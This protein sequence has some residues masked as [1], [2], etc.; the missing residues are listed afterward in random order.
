MPRQCLF[1]IVGIGASAGGLAAF[2]A[3]FTGMPKDSDPGMAFVIVQHLAPDHKSILCELIRRYTRMSVFEVEDGMVVQQNCAYIIPPGRDMAFLNGS[4]QL[5]PPAEPRGHRLPIDFFFRSLALDHHERAIGIIL[6]G[7]GSDG[8]LGLRAIKGEGGMIM[9]QSTDTAE[10]D[11]MPLSAIGTGLVDYVLPPTEMAERLISYTR[12][13]FSPPLKTATDENPKFGNALPK[14]FILL[15]SHTSHDFS[16]YKPSTIIRRIGRRMAVH[17]IDAIADYVHY[18]RQKPNEVQALFRDLLIGVTSFFR[19][20]EAFQILEDQVIPKLFNGKPAGSSIRIWIPGCST[21]EEAYS[22]AILL[23]E[24]VEALRQNYIVQVF[25]TD[26]DS[27]A[28]A[29]ARS[30]IYPASIAANIS[31]DRLARF[32]TTEKD[33][34]AYRID[35]S[36]RDFLFFS[37]HDLIKDPP[38]SKLDL[39][40]C[41][42]L[43]IY[44]G[45]ELQKN[46][47]PLF[48]YALKPNGTLFLGTS[49]GIGDFDNLFAVHDR[50][51]KL[52]QRKEGVRDD[53]RVGFSHVLPSR[54]SGLSPIVPKAASVA[55]VRESLRS[56]TERALLKRIVAAA[57]L[58]IFSTCTAAQAG[59]WSRPR[60]NRGSTIFSRCLGKAC[61]AT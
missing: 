45:S 50:K 29:T 1:P 55:R 54:E 49:E 5:L 60:A 16:L 27:H 48:H 40:S 32:F 10:F 15:R 38:L 51:A 44:M 11:G 2:E 47:I 28:I 12:H 6:S 43:L 23:M 46:L 41:R 31:P 24:H 61:G 14:I 52:F 53:Q 3:F 26:I 19:D 34:S 8:T 36:I 22:I 33:A 59:S 25:A 18:L 17:Q 30:G 42:N 4:L 7:T 20:P 35:K 21:G 56:T 58:A 9:T 37:E 13:A 57:A 39:I